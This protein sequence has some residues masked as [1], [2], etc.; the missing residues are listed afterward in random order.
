MPSHAVVPATNPATTSQLLT[1][2]VDGDTET[3]SAL[4][5]WSVTESTK[6]LS[7]VAYFRLRDGESAEAPMLTSE[8]TLNSGESNREWFGDQT[9]EITS[10]SIFLEVVSGSVEIVVYLG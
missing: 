2:T 7:A 8:V 1:L 10:G 6:A 3:P 9:I 4:F 5:G